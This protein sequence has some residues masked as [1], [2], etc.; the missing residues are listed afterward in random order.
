MQRI[1]AMTLAFAA[2]VGG[3]AAWAQP[4]REPV[5]LERFKPAV[6]HDPFVITEGTRV[7]SYGG[8]DPLNLGVIVNGSWNPLG[9]VVDG[10][11]VRQFVAR[12]VGVDIVGS[13]AL[14]NSFEL[15]VGLP[16]FLAQSGDIVTNTT[17]VGDLRLVP[18]WRIAKDGKGGAGLAV[19]PELRLPTH[20]DEEFSGG[21]RTPVF[22]PRLAMDHRFGM[23]L[24]IGAN[25][26]LA[27]RQA[28]QFQNIEAGSEITYSAAAAYHFGG[29]DGDVVVGVDL[30]GAAGLRALN[31]EEV[32]LEG[33]LYGQVQAT[34]DLQVQFGP[35]M[36]L[37]PGFGTPTFRL[38]AGLRWAPQSRDADGDGIKDKD[39]KCPD[40]AENFN[41]IEDDDGCP[42]QDPNL[43]L[44]RV[45]VVDQDDQPIRRSSARVDDDRAEPTGEPGVHEVEVEP[46]E[47]VLWVRA[48]GYVPQRIDIRVPKGGELEKVVKMAPIEVT[49][50]DDRIEFT[51]TVYFAFD[52]DRLLRESHDI[53]DEVA[54]VINAYKR[55][56][57][58]RVE[59]H[60]DKWGTDEYNLDLSRRRARSVMNY[61][62]ESGEVDPARLETEGYGEERPVSKVDRENRRVEF[63]I[64]RGRVP[65]AKIFNRDD[66]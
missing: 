8:E 38:F 56:R 4:V 24:R 44:V 43:G 61:L 27:L 1:V 60:A 34:P 53:L 35:A 51:G 31:R 59:G 66:R 30:H 63:V 39:D 13:Y 54:L 17:G 28:T 29:Y 21:A 58:I 19:I 5:D 22:A 57:L 33:Q 16:L 32:P 15:G 26:G 37:N 7:T 6:T 36:G 10:N 50:T 42:D 55:I 46:G 47:H 62:V 45:I 23:G 11:L 41:G 40:E 65:G 48:R 64:V 3:S 18:K 49:V 14:A 12:R 52:S 2:L 20:T 9:V 25:L